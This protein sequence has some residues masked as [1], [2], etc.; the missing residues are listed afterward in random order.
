MLKCFL[1]NYLISCIITFKNHH[2]HDNY[3]LFI[4]FFFHTFSISSKA[5]IRLC[6]LSGTGGVSRTLLSR[7]AVWT[8][9]LLK[10]ICII[11]IN[12]KSLEREV[13]WNVLV[14]N[15]TLNIWQTMIPEGNVKK[16][17]KRKK[18]NEQKTRTP[19][20]RS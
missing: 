10:K 18:W 2:V 6:W 8:L 14:M 5:T 11:S 9:Q 15:K 3:Y 1:N 4:Y 7:I 20:G 13:F 16:K 12:E 19:G 17:E